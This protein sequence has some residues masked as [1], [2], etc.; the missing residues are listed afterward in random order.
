MTTTYTE[1]YH[2]LASMLV[3]VG[4][5][6]LR[7]LFLHYVMTSSTPNVSQYLT[8]K[9]PE[10]EK[11]YKRKVLL[12]H[13]MKTLFPPA[14]SS[15]QD[16]NQW[17]ISLLSALLVN[18]A[19]ISKSEETEISQL[20]SLRNEIYGHVTSLCLD[21]VDLN[22]YWTQAQAAIATLATACNDVT[23][24][25]EIYD[26]ID[27]IKDGF[28]DVGSSLEVLKAWY[29]TDIK[30]GSRIDQMAD[31]LDNIQDVLNKTEETMILAR[32]DPVFENMKR[33]TRI[34]I[35]ET[36]K[37]P[38]VETDQYKMALDI[39]KDSRSVV[40]A[41]KPGEGKTNIALH[42]A[43]EMTSGRG[44]I[45]L[46]AASQWCH[47][48][49]TQC[50][51]IIIDDVFGKHT[52][53][54]G[55]V[56]DWLP[57]LENLHAFAQKDNLRIILT[58]RDNILLEADHILKDVE[59]MRNVVSLSSEKLTLS[60]KKHILQ[61]LLDFHNRDIS[62]INLDKCC[63]TYKAPLGF[64]YSC[65][66][67]AADINLFLKKEKFFLR[68]Q[69]FFQEVIAGLEGRHK[70]AFLFLFYKQGQCK[71]RDLKGRKTS[72]ENEEIREFCADIVGLPK[73]ELTFHTIRETLK[74]LTGIY[75]THIDQLF[76]FAHATIYEC[77]AFTHGIVFPEE[78]ITHCTY[79][80]LNACLTTNTADSD[81][82]MVVPKDKY[83][84]LID[85]MIIETGPSYDVSRLFNFRSHPVV[86]CGSFCDGFFKKLE[87]D[88]R[89]CAFLTRE[90]YG[91]YDYGGFLHRC[92][93]SNSEE[94]KQLT[95]S[96]VKFLQCLA[97]CESGCWK[98]RVKG[99]GVR[100]SCL[101]GDR[102]TFRELIDNGAHL[103]PLC[104]SDSCKGGDDELMKDVVKQLQSN[105]QFDPNDVNA[106]KAII[107]ALKGP[108]KKGLFDFLRHEGVSVTS[109]TLN[110]ICQNREQCT[111]LL[112]KAVDEMQR[113]GTWNPED[114]YHCYSL[115]FLITSKNIDGYNFLKSLVP[116]ISTHSLVQAVKTGDIDV[117]KL[118]VSDLKMRRQWYPEGRKN[119]SDFSQPP[120]DVSAKTNLAETLYQARRLNDSTILEYLK[121]E[122]LRPSMD[123]LQ[124]S[125]KENDSVAKEVI[126]D[127]KESGLWSPCSKAAGDALLAALNQGEDSFNRLKENGLHFVMDNLAEVL[128]SGDIKRVKCVIEDLK[129]TRTW[130]P[131]HPLA[132]AFLAKAIELEDRAIFDYLYENG[133]RVTAMT[134]LGEAFT[135]TV[136]S[137]KRCINIMKNAGTWNP[138]DAFLTVC[139]TLTRGIK[140]DVF[141]LFQQE[142][143]G[144]NSA[145]LL[146]MVRRRSIM[147][148]K[149]IEDLI[150]NGAWKPNDDKNIK[151]AFIFALSHCNALLYNV[152]VKK[153]MQVTK[154]HLLIVLES[155]KSLI[156]STGLCNKKRVIGVPSLSALSASIVASSAIEYAAENSYPLA[157]SICI[158]AVEES[159]QHINNYPEFMRSLRAACNK[160]D[161]L[162][163][164]ILADTELRPPKLLCLDAAVSAAFTRVVD[165][166]KNVEI[167]TNSA[168]GKSE[169]NGNSQRIHSEVVEEEQPLTD[170]VRKNDGKDDGQCLVKGGMKH[171][172]GLSG[173]SGDAT[174][175]GRCDNHEISKVPLFGAPLISKIKFI[176]Q[177]KKDTLL[178]MTLEKILYYASNSLLEEQA[179]N[180]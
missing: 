177:M 13:Q 87:T 15:S 45:V 139:L 180:Q 176:T 34:L 101:E 39:L 83:D 26:L 82:R 137:V 66:L 165:S 179:A 51:V 90:F 18:I 136:D 1:N 25:S 79:D 147:A 178:C 98:C 24:L 127:L 27:N 16:I 110:I 62:Q 134:I 99:D 125:V 14:G 6:V 75:I 133:L 86:L 144:C 30:E 28:L 106:S 31:T 160:C 104:L 169:L 48:D 61:V 59:I 141:E 32:S 58:S 126:A 22:K 84:V 91:D 69:T 112:K 57:I 7:R 65:F 163:Y 42:L 70:A 164:N 29:Q 130:T 81:S 41:G 135:G 3:D 167:E 103:S 173:G 116:C 156:Y 73:E 55:A 138:N 146:E 49:V 95:T 171:V 72:S 129:E 151:S 56:Q 100:A 33:H 89:L 159:G 44:C 150:Q 77:V 119:L 9:K 78:V 8:N 64:P 10:L 71:A 36:M 17:D 53:D 5:S 96:V 68:P 113:E 11:L 174:E 38:F 19:P 20:R 108:D 166:L 52:T 109:M 148:V 60:E 43:H 37:Q 107:Y 123:M 74:E 4:T 35:Q 50:D 152:F 175:T 46:Y 128:L 155:S 161:S 117:V 23:F 76:Q 47:V 118:V 143:V 105:S 97:K 92:I 102:K 120:H 170:I 12:G 115:S 131:Q 111:D 40:V 114:V 145:T 54:R 94:G 168:T 157:A 80:F 124:Y 121:S 172:E 142:G 63:T 149:T 122:G 153:G 67:F 88:G 140:P 162:M 154:C 158:R 2:R 21:D 132:T 93:S 85:R